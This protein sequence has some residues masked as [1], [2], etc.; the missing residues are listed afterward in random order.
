[1]EKPIMKTNSTVCFLQITTS[2]LLAIT[3]SLLFTTSAYASH[4]NLAI[5]DSNTITMN[6]ARPY[7]HA[8]NKLKTSNSN[9]SRISMTKT[10]ASHGGKP[11]HLFKKSRAVERTEFAAFET[12]STSKKVFERKISEGGKPRYLP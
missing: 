12:R 5:N 4:L 6:T 8:A 11:Y 3:S 2:S 10:K 9:Q 1:M 7:H